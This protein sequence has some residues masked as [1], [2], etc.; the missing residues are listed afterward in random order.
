MFLNYLKE[1]MIIGLIGNTKLNKE[2]VDYLVNDKKYIS[3]RI[4]DTLD[5]ICKELM[6]QKEEVRNVLKNNFGEN[7]FQK[8]LLKK[9]IKNKNQ[10]III[11]GILNQKDLDFLVHLPKILFLKDIEFQE[12]L[13]CYKPIYFIKMTDKNLFHEKINAILEKIILI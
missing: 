10:N 7:I 11:N 5:I 9:I 2:I 3:F 13:I 1:K 6:I 12:K 8:I 4:D